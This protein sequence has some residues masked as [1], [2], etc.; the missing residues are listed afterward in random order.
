MENYLQ[1][2]TDDIHTVVKQSL[3]SFEKILTVLLDFRPHWFYKNAVF[4]QP[5]ASDVDCLPTDCGELLTPIQLFEEILEKLSLV[6]ENKYWV[7]QNK[8]CRFVATINYNA[9]YEIVG[10]DKGEVYKVH[11]RFKLMS[12]I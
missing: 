11:R 12:K 7:V 6:F 4:M 8:Y 2:L 9:V 5:I 1:G 10:I 3:I